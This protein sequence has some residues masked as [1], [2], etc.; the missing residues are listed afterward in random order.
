[1]DAQEDAVIDVLDVTYV[2][3]S[4]IDVLDKTDIVAIGILEGISIRLATT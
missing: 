3:Y 2:V 1:M 4:V